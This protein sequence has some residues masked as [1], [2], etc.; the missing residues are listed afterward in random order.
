MVLAGGST[1]TS[2]IPLHQL[3]HGQ[4]S[5]A[6]GP[7]SSA[8]NGGG[9]GGALSVNLQL[10][11]DD[12]LHNSQVRAQAADLQTEL[13]APSPAFSLGPTGIAA[14]CAR[15]PDSVSRECFAPHQRHSRLCACARLRERTEHCSIRCHHLQGYKPITLRLNAL[16]QVPESSPASGASQRPTHPHH[17]PPHHDAPLPHS[18]SNG[19]DSGSSN[20][21]AAAAAAARRTSLGSAP[22]ARHPVQGPRQSYAAAAAATASPAQP[23]RLSQSGQQ[24]QQQQ[25]ATSPHP[26]PPSP[27][28]PPPPAPSPPAPTSPP[29]AASAP[30]QDPP[31]HTAITLTVA[32][33]PPMQPPPPLPPLSR[34]PAVADVPLIDR[35]ASPSPQHMQTILEMGNSGVLGGGGTAVGT[36][37]LS[38][39]TKGGGR[40]SQDTSQRTGRCATRAGMRKGQEEAH[41]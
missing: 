31:E 33:S 21:A 22:A 37:A 28:V 4:A 40:R 6:P 23:S 26:R 11:H 12:G 16:D 24:Q 29:A 35:A 3:Q 17:H 13:A 9:G 7:G 30:R 15:A 36:S 27:P 1:S 32:D 18:A 20:A 19:H 39:S 25:R 14:T 34:S 38:T 41:G 8:G 5:H 10:G 2:I